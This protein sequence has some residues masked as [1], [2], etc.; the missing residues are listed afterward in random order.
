VRRTSAK[1]EYFTKADRPSSQRESASFTEDG[2]GRADPSRHGIRLIAIPA[3]K[4]V[5]LH[6]SF[7]PFRLTIPRAAVG[8]T[9][10][11]ESALSRA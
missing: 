10:R 3:L 6:S 8:V 11:T 4:I 5:I 7:A 9:V 1:R 2:E